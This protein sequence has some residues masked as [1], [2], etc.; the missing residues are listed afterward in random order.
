[1]AQQRVETS[2]KLQHDI[3]RLK[4]DIARLKHDI[5]RLKHGHFNVKL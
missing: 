1:M 2:Q 5:A 3:A 4:H